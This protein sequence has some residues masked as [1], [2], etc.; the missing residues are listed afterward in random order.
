MGESDYG[1]TI[2][3]ENTGTAS[4]PAFAPPE[5]NPFG[6]A[7][8]GFAASP[9]FADLDSD[10]DL[11]AFVG[12]PYGATLLFENTGTASAPAF[13]PPEANPFGLADVGDRASPAFA[14]LDG[15]GDLD[16]FV[17]NLD[18]R[19]VFF[20]NLA[21][22]C[23]SARAPSCTGG[24][25]RASLSVDERRSGKE[26]LSASF[27][28]GP[29]LAQVQFGD[30]TLVGGTDVALCVY[31]DDGAR[32]AALEVARAGA[33]CGSKPC[34]KPL[35]KPSPDG[36]GFAYKDAA[37]SADGVR[38]LKLKGAG[39]GKSSL[40]VGA[41]NRGPTVASALPTGIAAALA[42]TTEVTLQLHTSDGACFEATL[43]D[44]TRQEVD[45]FKAR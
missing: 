4:A 15:D 25:A 11:D 34:W 5:T 22:L 26:K 39:A 18:G 13:A 2:L 33:S 37:G 35:G 9:A 7:S 16:A 40:S 6:L 24:F 45:R 42:T 29:A 14:D 8:V 32:A 17:G 3:F 28:K 1:D 10:G 41:S 12:E 19:T 20:E 36:R 27:S 38:S 44:V 23:P 21:V 30:P 31:K 43:D